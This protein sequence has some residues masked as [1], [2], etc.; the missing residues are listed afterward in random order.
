MPATSATPV[1]VPSSGAT[2]LSL[3]DHPKPVV[4]ATSSQGCGYIVALGAVAV[5]GLV[6]FLNSDHPFARRLRRDAKEARD[7]LH[8]SAERV[9]HRQQ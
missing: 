7:N 8:D 4:P 5:V 9:R 2:P 1:Y 3:V 6:C